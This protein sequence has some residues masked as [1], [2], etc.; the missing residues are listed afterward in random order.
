MKFKSLLEGLVIGVPLVFGTVDNSNTSYASESSN[1]PIASV[2]RVGSYQKPKLNYEDQAFES[3][4]WSR[5][6]NFSEGAILL[7]LSYSLFKRLGNLKSDD[8]LTKFIN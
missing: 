3:E 8:S 6:F 1:A 2:I 5:Y 7:Y 4:V